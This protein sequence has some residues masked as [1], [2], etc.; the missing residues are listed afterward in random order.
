M[1]IFV[2]ASC[3]AVSSIV[4]YKFEPLHHHFARRTFFS[5]EINYQE[6]LAFCVPEDEGLGADEG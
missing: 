3:L 5:S 1:I 4:G 2:P 6:Q